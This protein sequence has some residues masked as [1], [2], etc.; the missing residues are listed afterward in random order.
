M[1]RHPD[2]KL[3]LEQVSKRLR[4][5]RA[6]FTRKFV[7][8]VGCSF[9]QYLIDRRVEQAASLLLRTELD[10][11]TIADELGF[12]SPSHF[13]SVFHRKTGL[14]PAT[15]RA[16]QQSANHGQHDERVMIRRRSIR[17]AAPL[18]A[19]IGVGLAGRV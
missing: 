12:S 8:L 6:A 4:L 11:S 17:S 14:T 9:H 3:S 16:R 18:S 5:S 7:D 2:S 1:D 19:S 10:I 15:T 13:V